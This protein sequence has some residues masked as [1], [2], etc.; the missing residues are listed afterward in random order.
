MPGT[1]TPPTKKPRKVR[2][3]VTVKRRATEK[4]QTK[5][6]FPKN[7]YAPKERYTVGPSGKSGK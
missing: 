1:G 2:L 7:P 3:V 6:K 4:G 5:R